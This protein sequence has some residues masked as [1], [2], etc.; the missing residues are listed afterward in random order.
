MEGGNSRRYDFHLQRPQFTTKMINIKIRS[1]TWIW[2]DLFQDMILV[3]S[4]S[5]T[6]LYTCVFVLY[7]LTFLWGGEAPSQAVITATVMMKTLSTTDRT[8]G[9]YSDAVSSGWRQTWQHTWG[10]DRK[11]VTEGVRRGDTGDW[12]IPTGISTFFKIPLLTCKAFRSPSCPASPHLAD[13]LF[14]VC[15][16]C[17]LNPAVTLSMCQNGAT[18][19]ALL[20]SQYQCC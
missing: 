18:F 10:G 2:S 20:V 9:T 8:T 6:V 13:F 15:I 19:N 7:S 14:T 12:K 4:H 1:V 17:L 16:E 3:P 11:H 5:P